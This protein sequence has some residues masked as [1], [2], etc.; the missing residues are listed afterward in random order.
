[1]SGLLHSYIMYIAIYYVM[2]NTEYISICIY[3]LYFIDNV[4]VRVS[5]QF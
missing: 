5:V 3:L 4:M 2:S 1:M